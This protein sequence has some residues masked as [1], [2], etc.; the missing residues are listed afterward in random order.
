MDFK[1]QQLAETLAMYILVGFAAIAFLVGYLRQDFGSMMTLFGSGC[2]VACVVAVPD[3]PVY[4]KHPVKWLP[5]KGDA[6]GK[7]QKRGGGGTGSDGSGLA[8]KKQK[9]GSWSN[10]WGM[11]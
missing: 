2:A 6:A 10:L 7:Q 3:W 9:E 1:G 11:F 4:N 8:R 5:A